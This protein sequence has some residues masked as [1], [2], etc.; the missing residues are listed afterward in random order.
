MKDL[1]YFPNRD[2]YDGGSWLVGIDLRLGGDTRIALEVSAPFKTICK[3]THKDDDIEY[4]NNIRLWRFWH[5]HPAIPPHADWSASI[6]GVYELT[7]GECKS[8]GKKLPSFD[9]LV[10]MTKLGL[11]K[12]H[13]GIGIRYGNSDNIYKTMYYTGRRHERKMA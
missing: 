5:I 1:P 9:T 2:F 3:H 8:C 10:L 12:P 7:D 6:D 13:N 4:D 11:F